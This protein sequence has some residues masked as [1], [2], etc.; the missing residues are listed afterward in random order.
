MGTSVPSKRPPRAL[1][2]APRALENVLDIYPGLTATLTPPGLFRGWGISSE[3]YRLLTRLVGHPTRFPRKLPFRRGAV[4]PHECTT[5]A[6]TVF[7]FTTTALE[8]R[9]STPSVVLI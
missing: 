6:F 8:R 9:R 5:S 3:T 1:P 2:P 4:A 7:V